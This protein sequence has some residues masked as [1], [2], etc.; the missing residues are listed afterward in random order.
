MADLLY[1]S[2]MSLLHLIMFLSYLIMAL[3][4]LHH[5]DKQGGPVDA[6][7]PDVRGR[8]RFSQ[9]RLNSGGRGSGDI[10]KQ[11]QTGPELFP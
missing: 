7:D 2:N 8:R 10:W 5:S 1:L 4:L 3:L 11:I 6:S 9:L